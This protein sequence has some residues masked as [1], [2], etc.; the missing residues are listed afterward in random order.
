MADYYE[1]AQKVLRGGRVIHYEISN[2]RSR[3]SNRGQ[4]EI[5]GAR[6]T[7]DLGLGAFVSGTERWANAHDAA[8]YVTAVQGGRLPMSQMKG[9]TAESALAEE[10]LF[11]GLRQLDGIC[12]A[13]SSGS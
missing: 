4:P 13:E 6:H 7:W 2:W 9:L 3:G 11:L 5:C 8:G 10:E 12:V 1:M